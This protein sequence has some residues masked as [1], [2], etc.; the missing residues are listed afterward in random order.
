M[1]NTLLDDVV[2]PDVILSVSLVLPSQG[3]RVVAACFLVDVVVVV[4]MLF[5]S[6]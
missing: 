2:E 4:G 1:P 5:S 6:V 3:L